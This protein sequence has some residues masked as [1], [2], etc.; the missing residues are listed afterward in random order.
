MIRFKNGPSDRKLVYLGFT[1]IELLVVIAII[2]VLV[3]I[4][5]PAVQQA[6]EAA[7]RSQCKNNLKQLGLA[8][9]NYHDVHQTFPFRS[10]GTARNAGNNYGNR[11]RL[12]GLVSILPF[13]EQGALY[14]QISGPLGTYPA[15]GP[16]PW[17]SA[18]SYAPWKSQTPV[19]LC[20]SA[21][22]N[23]GSVS[24]S[25]TAVNSYAFCAGDSYDVRN[26]DADSQGR[27]S[28]FQHP[29]G[30]FGW[31]VC[32]KFSDFTDGMSNTILMAEKRFPVESRDIGHSVQ[33]VTS[34][35]PVDCR[36]KFDRSTGIYS[37]SLTV[38][39]VQG[40]RWADGGS[41][42]AS[43][44]TILPPNS[45]SCLEA[46]SDEGNGFHSAGSEHQGGCQVVLGDGS[47]RF[48]SDNIDS[49]DQ[50]YDASAVSGTSPYGVWGSLG[51]KS[52]GEVTS[53]F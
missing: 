11:W 41:S 8:L 31:I 3:A 35:I 53:S 1:L 33:S 16:V 48:I 44:N 21:G 46:A 47:V 9:H 39:A 15:M 26:A 52:A 6:R 29:R 27:P 17:T 25:A 45:P 51:T 2:A 43:F 23:L 30:G 14:D 22:E 19:Y 12:S 38:S 42:Y 50:S 34:K 36:S 18:S 32:S 5:L 4:L 37:T 13:V 28:N 10:G 40:T 49:G 7:R 20:P 24:S